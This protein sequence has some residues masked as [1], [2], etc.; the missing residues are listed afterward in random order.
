MSALSGAGFKVGDLV[1]YSC[2]KES[3]G[4]IIY[5]ISLNYDSPLPKEERSRWSRSNI[6][7]V[8]KKLLKHMEVIGYMRLKPVFSFFPTYKGKKPS[9]LNSTVL[10][11]HNDIKNVVKVDLLQLASKYAELGNL[12]RDIAV[13]AGMATPPSQDHDGAHE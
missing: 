12:V 5:Q 10:V 11:Y 4:G 7:P 9:G 1:T 3:T 2:D 13:A 8:T 6:H